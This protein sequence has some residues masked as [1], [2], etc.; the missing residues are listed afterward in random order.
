[1]WAWLVALVCLFPPL[2]SAF[3]QDEKPTRDF[4]PPKIVNY[5]QPERE[6]TTQTLA[7]WTVYL[8]KE[9]TDRFP[10][11]AKQTLTRLE[12]K[13]RQL[14]SLLPT[15]THTP[16]QRLP[17]FVLLGDE[18]QNGGRNNG[19]EYFQKNAPD[20]WDFL[21]KRW[22]SAIVLYSAR[23]YV[24]LDEHWSVQ[25]LIHE[26]AHAWHLEHWE[27]KQADILSAWANAT[28]KRLYVRVKD[29]NGKVLESAYASVNQL[30]YFAEL[31]CA[32]FWRGEYEPFDR[33]A[34]Q[35][36]DPIGFAMLEKMWGIHAPPPFA[37]PKPPSP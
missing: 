19:A 4:T 28:A 10:E 12:A 36:H 14:K 34:L 23:N 5:R 35:N 8:E 6:Y 22:R 15:H 3:A 16:L 13:L 33:M 21:D 17:L 32:Y 24:Q 30:E 27:E 26:F 2:S 7:G 20:F 11:L 37:P 25:V 29:V 1:L 18:S 31:S 9:T